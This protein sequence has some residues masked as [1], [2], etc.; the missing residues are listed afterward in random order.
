V[1]AHCAAFYA[2]QQRSAVP[3]RHPG[4]GRRVPT[5]ASRPKRNN[6][7]T[8]A[9]HRPDSCHSLEIRLLRWHRR[10]S[11]ACDL[12]E[13]HTPARRRSLGVGCDPQ[14]ADLRKR[15]RGK[16]GSAE[17][18]PAARHRR[19]PVARVGSNSDRQFLPVIQELVDAC[20]LLPQDPKGT[21]SPQTLPIASSTRRP[22]LRS[23]PDVRLSESLLRQGNLH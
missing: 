13:R 17:M 11:A 4:A 14:A 8:N 16:S 19:T 18:A 9:A 6:F 3:P 10:R 20:R 22:S 5:S 23:G 2:L 7:T 1:G 21:T 15:E 12:T